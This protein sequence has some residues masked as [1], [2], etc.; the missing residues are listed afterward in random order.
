MSTLALAAT[1]SA[2]QKAAAGSAPAQSSSDVISLSPFT[3]STEKD[4]GYAA[5]STLA[6]S[7]LNTNIA[8]I[9]ASIT[10]VTKQQMEDTASLN[11][12]DVF[13]YEANTEGSSTYTPYNTDGRGTNKD[14]IG[15]YTLGNDGT[16]ITNS[17]SNRVRGLSAPDAALNYYPTNNRIPFDSY[18]T[19]SVEIAR[20]PNSLLFGLGSPAGIVNQ[21]TAQAMLNKNTNEVQL[22][23][24]QYGTARSSL[25]I[26]RS[27]IKDTLA[28]YGAYLYD[29][30]Q[31]R[32]RPSYDLTRREYGA[33]TFRPF[34]NTVIRGFAEGYLNNANRPNFITPRDFVTPWLQAGRPAYDPITRTVTI[35]DTGK[36]TGPYTLSTLSPG[37]V[38]GVPASTAALTS[39]TSPFYV[40]GITF[41]DV[42]RPLERISGENGQIIDYFQRQPNL[43]VSKFTNPAQPAPTPANQGWVPQDPRYA[44]N[45][46]LWTASQNLPAP[47]TTI[48]GKTYTYGTWLYPAVTNKAIYDWTKYNINQTNTAKTRAANYNLELEQQITPDLFLS[49]GW[50]RQDI[51]NVANYTLSQLTGATL[52]IDTN[53]NMPDGRPNPYFGKVFVGELGPDTFYLPE[54]DDNFRVMLAY[55]LDLAKRGGWRRFLGKHRILGLWSEQDAL[56]KTERWRTAFLG[57]DADG[58]LRY[59]P[60]PTLNNGYNVWNDGNAARHY[61]LASPSSP[62]ATVTS[63]SGNYSNRGWD[64]P[65]TVPIHVYNYNTGQ[66]QDDSMQ[67]GTAFSEAGSFTLQREVKSTNFAVQSNFLEDRL[68]TTLGWRHDQYRARRTTTGPI[69]DVSGKIMEPSLTALQIHHTGNGLSDYNLVMNRWNRWDKL[70]GNTKTFGA[71]F[72][73]LKGMAFAERAGG[74]GSVLSQFLQSLTLY[75]NE[76]ANFNPPSTFQTDYFAKPLPKPTGSGHDAGIGFTLFDNKLS[77]RLNWYSVSD[78]NER[79]TTPTVLSRLAYGDTTLMQPWASAVVRIRNGANTA[80]PTWNTD[81]TNPLTPEMQQQVADLMKLPWNWYSGTAIGSTQDA[82]AKG[83]ELQITYNPT[84]NWTMKITASHQKT[85]YTNV[86]PQYDSWFAVRN[87]IWTSATAPDIPDFV[88]GGGV[89]VSLKDFW[90]GYGYNSTVRAD[91]AGGNTTSERYFT[92]VVASNYALAKALEGA[93]ATDQRAYHAA[94]ITNYLFTTGRLKGFSVGG[95]ERWESRATLGYLGKVADPTQPTVINA[96]DPTKPIWDKGNNYVDLWFAYSHRIWRD[97]INWKL[98]LNINNVTESGRLEATSVNYDG[99][100][101]AFRIIDPRQFVLT[102]TFTF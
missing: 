59:M 2:Q 66:F 23:T 101:Y 88:D 52:T 55:N 60:N 99:S 56:S 30:E 65:F 80:V 92:N 69:T 97:K 15:G 22:R 76:S 19:Q 47:T 81:A 67:V 71:A 41:D 79:Q 9:A 95:A 38:A 28:V 51:D 12:N 82:E 63:S 8:D 43:V 20:G 11:I 75:L 83:E 34:K 18:N 14:T 96:L 21:S 57:G 29:N 40:P 13:R 74:N 16:T 25:A 37:Y 48:N 98:Q 86:S 91:D 84:R 24:D 3:V 46:R 7:R 102:S 5:E 87:P 4:T 70:T 73:P 32:R 72:R 53:L 89:Q 90:H 49:A 54:T 39:T 17:Q 1:A 78:K 42:T 10:V 6:G 77:F 68:V 27:V 61:Y 26:N 85:V 50:L 45:E 44:I 36:K 62:D 58:T 31:F 33:V 100:P 93:A 35:L 94:I 64:T